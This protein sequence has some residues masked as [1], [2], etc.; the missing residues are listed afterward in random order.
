MLLNSNADFIAR[1]INILDLPFMFSFLK[2]C[3]MVDFF[4]SN[5]FSRIV[6]LLVHFLSTQFISFI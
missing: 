4:K 1:Y 5:I 2:Y 6:K 3:S